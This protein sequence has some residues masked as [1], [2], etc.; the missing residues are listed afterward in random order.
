MRMCVL[1]YGLFQ[2]HQNGRVIGIPGFLIA[3]GSALVLVDTGFPPRYAHDPRGAA[4]ADGL[5]SFGQIAALTEEQLPDAQLAR[6]GFAPADITHLLLTHT[7]ID[8][9]GGIADFP[10]ATIIVGQ[11]ER[12]LP[13]PIYWESGDGPEWPDGA[14]Y[15]TIERDTDLLPGVTLLSTP[16]HTPGHLS[17]LVRLPR[18]GPVLLTGDAI[19]RPDEV[20][21]GS[22]GGAWDEDA[23]RTSAA[24]LMRIAEETS[25]LVIYGHDPAQWP[26]L[27][28]A[29]DWYD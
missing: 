4:E 17:L 25:A 10:R 7:H 5:T 20:A 26:G 3:A 11:A 16:G 27:R 23:A 21:Q 19:N 9:V 8:H 14:S 1:D 15:L 29:P 28:K 24:R 13:R 6:A 2:V 12:A 18:T 22:F